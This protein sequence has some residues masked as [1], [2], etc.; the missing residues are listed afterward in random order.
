[1]ALLARDGAGQWV[2]YKLDRGIDHILVDEAQDTSPDQW[3]VIRMLSEEF[4]A[5]LGQ[6]NLQRTL[7]AV[8]DEKQSIYSFQGAVPEDFAAQGRSVSLRAGDADL[9]FERVSLNFSFRSAPDVLQ[10]VDEVFARP[11]ANR[12][13]AGATVHDAIR[14]DAPGEVEIWDMLTP[15]AVE[16]PDDWRVPVDHLAAPAVR[17][18]EQIAATIRYWLDRGE[19]IPGQNRSIAPRDIMVLV[20]KRDQFMPALSRALKNLGVPVAG[21]DRLRLTSHIAIQDLMALGRFVLQPSDDLSLASLLKSPLFGWDDD[22]LFALAYPR[23]SS[24]TLFEH[25]YRVSRDDEAL[26]AIHKTLSRWRGMADTMP[27]FEFYARILS[28]D[29]A[30]RKLL[31]RLGPEAGDIIDEFQN[32]ALSAERAGLPGLQAFLETLDAASPE[33]KR[34]LDQGRNEVRLMTVH[35]AKGLE[36]AVVFLVDP[37]SAVWTGSRAPKLIPYD[38]PHDG[39]PVKG[40]LWQ[41][42]GGW[43]TG[44]TASRVEELKARAEEE[45]RRLLYVGMTR[46]EDRLIICGYRGTRESGETW[47]RLAEDALA[48]KSETYVHPVQG[49]AARRYRNTPRGLTEIIEPD[50]ADA[51]PLP[52]LPLEYLLPVKPEAGLPRPLAP[53]GASALIE[54]DEEPPLDISSPVLGDI[55]GE[56]APGFALRRGTAIHMLLQYLPEVP[57]GEREKLAEDYLARIA[58]DWPEAERHNAAL[59]VKAILGDQRFAPVFASGSR[60]EVAIMGTIN[61]GGRDHAVS[62]QVDR[63]SVDETSVLVVDYKT[64]RPPPKTVEAVPFAYRAQLAL[65]KALLEPLY[66]GRVVET[67]LLFTEG[68]FLLPLS[69]AVLDEAMRALKDSQGKF[70]N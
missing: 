61:L 57:E 56:G 26:G 16:E 21:A 24:S 49:V 54:A 12:G 58:G 15:E 17:L 29:G 38:L 18:A 32:Y 48:V 46:A 50:Q 19:P 22:R 5:G 42:N 6:R 37:G 65:Y 35:A 25:L 28:A 27:V 69:D 59:S 3:Q 43:Q 20:R 62:G 8:G 68:P 2:Q 14:A 36:G 11:E 64:N 23:G 51:A 39:A 52:A 10:A 60:G 40:Y 4:F 30:R 44:F 55:V 41:P 70:N 67:A 31:A 34:E 47:H 1:M 53:S 7:F 9:K 33:I 45:Y 66:P 13:L 63:I